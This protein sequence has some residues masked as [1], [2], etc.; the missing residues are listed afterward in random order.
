[1]AG[2]NVEDTGGIERGAQCKF[3]VLCHCDTRNEEALACS[4]NV[5]IGTSRGAERRRAVGDTERQKQ[6]GAGDHR[7]DAGSSSSGEDAEGASDVRVAVED[8]DWRGCSRKMG[9]ESL[10]VTVAAVR[11][12]LDDKQSAGARRSTTGNCQ[13][14][15]RDRVTAY[16]DGSGA[17]AVGSRETGDK[18]LRGMS[19]HLRQCGDIGRRPSRAED[20]GN[21]E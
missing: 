17:G 16:R 10:Q 6:S 19:R 13:S 11:E 2:G 20:R 18:A 14:A 3:E 5:H 21:A 9:R 4:V 12:G 1:V 7:S 8:D 15:D